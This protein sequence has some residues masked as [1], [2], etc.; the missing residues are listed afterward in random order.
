MVSLQS[1]RMPCLDGLRGL[2]ASLVV[3]GHDAG[4][5]F[6][7]PFAPHSRDYGVMLFFVLSGFLMGS[8]YLS[9]EPNYLSAFDYAVSRSA[10]IIPIYFIV[11]LLSFVFYRFIDSGFVYAIDATQ[12]LRLLTFNGSVSVFWS[13]G[14]EMQ[15][16]VVFLLLWF[17]YA[18]SRLTFFIIVPLVSIACLLTVPM[19]PGIFV[20]S[21]FHI[22]AVGVLIAALRPVALPS[23]AL[24]FLQIISAGLLIGLICSDSL[25]ELLGYTTTNDP[26]LAKFYGSWTRLLVVGLIV[27]SL[28][29]N[30]RIGVA[31]LA[32]RFIV[33]LGTISFSLYLLHE[34]VMYFFDR[35][36]INQTIGLYPTTGLMLASVIMVSWASYLMIERPAR[37]FLSK[38]RESGRYLRMRPIAR[39]PHSYAGSSDCASE[40]QTPERALS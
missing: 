8:R 38:R 37:I 3:I 11:V 13:I 19:W 30:S 18:R 34:P 17:V 23:R 2:A 36:E 26:K 40:K 32:N 15:F 16:Y 12:L 5:G 33:F 28:S 29:Y 6:L 7:Q 31:L 21:K 20:L 4:F 1:E 9:T 27:F 35:F 22:F 10:R 25:S 14:P 24:G 39:K